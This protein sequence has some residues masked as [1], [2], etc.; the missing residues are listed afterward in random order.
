MTIYSDGKPILENNS[1]YM[2]LRLHLCNKDYGGIWSSLYHLIYTPIHI[3]KGFYYGY[4]LEDIRWFVD[5]HMKE[6]IG[7]IK[8]RLNQVSD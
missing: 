6:N 1:G 2:S 8:R 5:R 3:L 4:S 7:G